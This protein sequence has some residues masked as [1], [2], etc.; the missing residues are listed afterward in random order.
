MIRYA[1]VGLSVIILALGAWAI[2][3]LGEYAGFYGVTSGGMVI[4]VV[5]PSL[6]LTVPDTP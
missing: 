4:F 2:A 1:I 3:I 6:P 5:R